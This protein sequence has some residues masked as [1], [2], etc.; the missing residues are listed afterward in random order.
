MTFLSEPFQ[1]DIF[2]SYSHGDVDG[3][4]RS[5]LKTWSQAFVRELEAELRTH[6]KFSNLSIFLDQHQHREQALD[7]MS[8]LTQQ[9]RDE[10]GK[11]G[12]LLVLMG[13]HYLHSGWCGDE[14]DWWLSAQ[15]DLGLDHQGRMAVV[16]I[17]PTDEPW[18]DAFCDERGNPLVG[19]EFHDPSLGEFRPQPFG[20]PDPSGNNG[21]FRDRLLDLVGSIW[22]KLLAFQQRIEMQC[23]ADAE[24]RRLTADQGQVV[25]LHGRR[26]QMAAWDQ[27]RERLEDSNFIVMPTEPDP[28][29]RDPA[30]V[31]AMTDQRIETLSGC[32]GLLLLATE[33]GRALDADLVVVGRQ[34]CNSARARSARRLPCA[35]LD[36]MGPVER[37]IRSRSTAERLG[38]DWIDTRSD[39][40][41]PKVSSWLG[42]AAIDVRPVT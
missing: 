24:V 42:D 4:G 13:P 6:P 7:P 18:P 14:R 20:W 41:T 15:N 39:I 22:Q 25:Y 12:M 8:P 2:V 37:L 27:A 3:S 17:W 33:D 16:R 38:I 36:T 23:Q 21:P 5:P 29:E 30:S 19:F 10:I 9:L 35:V 31:R 1:H 40:W 11:T 34:D 26:T 28:V 32:D